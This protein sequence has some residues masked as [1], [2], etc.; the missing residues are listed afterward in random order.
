VSN[1]QVLFHC[2]SLSHFLVGGNRRDDWERTG[3]PNV[4]QEDFV[5]DLCQTCRWVLEVMISPGHAGDSMDGKSNQNTNGTMAPPRLP[6]HMPKDTTFAGTRE[7]VPPARSVTGVLSVA[8]YESHPQLSHG[9]MVEV[10]AS[11]KTIVGPNRHF[12]KPTCGSS[13]WTSRHS[14][15][16]DFVV[17]G[18]K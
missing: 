4:V 12:G 2:R 8:T 1:W 9:E 6:C 15:G 13:R 18:M 7:Y 17:L 10:I 5:T 3:Q 14:S 16:R 11:I